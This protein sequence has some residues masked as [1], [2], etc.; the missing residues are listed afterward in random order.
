MND[1]VSLVIVAVLAAIVWLV[2]RGLE[3][4]GADR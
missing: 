1:V 2:V 3:R 4:L